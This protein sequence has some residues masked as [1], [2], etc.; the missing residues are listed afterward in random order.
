MDL[1][2]YYS[3]VR[4]AEAAL[5]EEHPVMIS[6]ATSE[7]GKAGVPT[8][9]PRHVAAKLIAEGRAR[10]ATGE[11]SDRFHE[12]HREARAKFEQQEMAHRIRVMVIPQQ[13]LKG[14]GLPESDSA[15]KRDRS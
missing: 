14:S 3:K 11:E 15:G 8:E 6:L 13:D 9:T 12:S 1:R 10:L 2:V 7:G 4:E 5:T